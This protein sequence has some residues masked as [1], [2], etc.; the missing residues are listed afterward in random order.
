MTGRRS[1]L[2]RLIG[3]ALVTAAAAAALTAR[4]Q[5]PPQPTFKTE[6]N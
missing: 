5:D 6:A 2:P 3:G 4:P 1:V